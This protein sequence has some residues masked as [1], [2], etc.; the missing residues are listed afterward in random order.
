MGINGLVPC[1]GIE[2][3]LIFSSKADMMSQ[4][5][6][7]ALI[8]LCFASCFL[9]TLASQATR[10]GTANLYVLNRDVS[11]D[12]RLENL[13][14]KDY[15]EVLSKNIGLVQSL[16][17]P[18]LDSLGHS[19]N[20]FEPLVLNY[21]FT[22]E[23][24]ETLGSERVLQGL[25]YQEPI[26]LVDNQKCIGKAILEG[27]YN[28]EQERSL[29]NQ[30]NAK[31]RAV[32]N[33]IFH[34]FYLFT[35][36]PELVSAHKNFAMTAMVSSTGKVNL[37]Q[38]RDFK[39]IFLAQSL[40]E[41]LNPEFKRKFS[42]DVNGRTIY[43]YNTDE[44]VE[45]TEEQDVLFHAFFEDLCS[46]LKIAEMVQRDRHVL[47]LNIYIRSVARL[48]KALSHSEMLM[49]YDIVRETLRAFDR[50]LRSSLASHEIEGHVLIYNPNE[51]V[52]TPNTFFEAKKH[53]THICESKSAEQR[54][55]VLV[56]KGAKGSLNIDPLNYQVYVW[57]P[58]GFALM[59]A[60]ILIKFFTEET[61]KDTI[62]YA[63]FLTGVDNAGR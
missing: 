3:L 61:P 46:I 53:L 12:A 59:L 32:D 39:R 52:N 25:T 45:Y 50:K 4:S 28:L 62:L 16:E 58:V 63:K 40:G 49:I 51:S 37:I 6:R 26:P 10:K 47:L 35:D 20:V 60:F 48:E 5:G 38:A 57:F 23:T 1:T 17:D 29:V 41:C 13:S 33:E 55:T 24:E 43:K 11:N 56:Q 15:L 7:T 21:I 30:F 19:S 9:S 14:V 54:G 2:S 44:K 27:V 42:F 18:R 34:A 36:E 22:M 31:L 8:F